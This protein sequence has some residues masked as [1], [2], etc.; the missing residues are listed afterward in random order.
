ME[1]LSCKIDN[2]SYVEVESYIAEYF[3]MGF[4]ESSNMPIEFNNNSFGNYYISATKKLGEFS[5]RINKQTDGSFWLYAYPY[6][7]KNKKQ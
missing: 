1:C 7:L 2:L 6:K 5:I 4:V 3:N